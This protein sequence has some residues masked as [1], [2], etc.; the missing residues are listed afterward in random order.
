MKYPV[1]PIRLIVPQSPG[2]ATDLVG[3]MVAAMLSERLGQ[4]VVVDNRPG[5]A[6][7]VG[8]ELA[9]KADPDGYTLLM[10]HS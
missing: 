9:S 2:G 7:I 3:R 5:A 6:T 8:T 10:V 4:P 1:R